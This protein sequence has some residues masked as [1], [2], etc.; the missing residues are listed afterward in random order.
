MSGLAPG[1]FS[2]DA[3]RPLAAHRAD[4]VGQRGAEPRPAPPL[5]LLQLDVGA[6]NAGRSN[7]A[8]SLP[9]DHL[10]RRGRAVPAASRAPSNRAVGHRRWL[11]N[12]FATTMGSGST[13]TANAMTVIGPTSSAATEPGVGLVA[14]RRLLPEAPSSRAAA[15]RSRP[16]TGAPSFRLRNGAGLP[17]RQAGRARRRTRSS[18]GTPS[19]PWSGRCRPSI[20]TSGHL[21]GRRAA[22]SGQP[23]TAKRYARTYGVRMFTPRGL[24]SPSTSPVSWARAERER[25]WWAASPSVVVEVHP[26]LLDVERRVEVLEVGERLLELLL[27]A[28]GGPP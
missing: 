23:G 19:R 4:D 10:G 20:A 22:A 13:S 25:A 5:A 11:L 9:V 2:T 26:H 18:P 17:R 24:S 14:D 27:A 12:P 6:A 15:G 21:Q 28:G 3:E 8:L 7:L 1:R 16:A